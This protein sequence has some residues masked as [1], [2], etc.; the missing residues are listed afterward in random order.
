MRVLNLHCLSAREGHIAT[1]E[2]DNA[3]NSTTSIHGLRK[4]P[5][6]L[7]ESDT[8]SESRGRS[9]HRA[10]WHSGDRFC[11][12]PKE[13]SNLAMIGRWNRSSLMKSLTFSVA[14]IG[15]PGW[16]C[17][18]QSCGGGIPSAGSFAA[19]SKKRESE[20]V[21]RLLCERQRERRTNMPCNCWK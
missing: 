20:P 11:F 19:S 14:I 21:T 2:R 10:L 17:W 13:W 15:S 5:S 16:N 4:L 3:A 9:D 6:V 12:G 8:Q 18:S 1:V 7:V